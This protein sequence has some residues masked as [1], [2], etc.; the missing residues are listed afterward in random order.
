METIEEAHV[1]YCTNPRDATGL[2][3]PHQSRPG[4]SRG[5]QSRGGRFRV[6]DLPPC[7]SHPRGDAHFLPC[8]E[9]CKSVGAVF[10]RLK[11]PLLCINGA[12]VVFKTLLKIQP[13]NGTVCR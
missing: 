13:L 3:K 2:P 9:K 7:A 4:C 11:R 10:V 1:H 6:F 8:S 12:S 5:G